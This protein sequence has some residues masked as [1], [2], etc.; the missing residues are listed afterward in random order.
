M[1]N[2]TID[3]TKV[4]IIQA[5]AEALWTGPIGET[6]TAGEYYRLN[7]TTGKME[8]GN[9]TSTTELGSIAGILIDSVATAN[10]AGTVVLLGSKALIDLGDALDGL[11]YDAAVY[12][13]DTD[14]TLSDTAGTSSRV[15]GRV[16]GLWNGASVDKVLYLA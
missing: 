1:G 15:V 10:L 4:H 9:G 3:A 11:A 14:A 2:L 16:Y 8:N 13:G 7:T 5:P 12:I 6:G